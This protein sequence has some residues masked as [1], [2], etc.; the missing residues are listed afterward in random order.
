MH[1]TKT[2]GAR[3]KWENDSANNITTTNNNNSN[4]YDNNRNVNKYCMIKLPGL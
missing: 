3:P 4:N 1:Y 2:Y